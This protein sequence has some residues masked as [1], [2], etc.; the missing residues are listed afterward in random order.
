MRR[1]VLVLAFVSAHALLGCEGS[2]DDQLLL[3]ASSG[4][5]GQGLSGAGASSGSAGNGQAGEG[6]LGGTQGGAGV[7]AL[8]GAG[9]AA[10]VGVGVGGDA[11]AAGAVGGQG[12]A[13]TSAQSDA[14][15]ASGAGGEAGASGVGAGGA[16]G[17]AAG[18]A[19]TSGEPMF[20]PC[21]ASGDCKVL[22][23]GD[24]ITFGSTANVGG[25]R[26]RLFAR[27]HA[28]GKHITF[29]GSQENGP[30]LVEGVPFPRKNEGHPGWTIAQITNI[31]DTSQALR[32]SPQIV[33]LHIGTNDMGSMSMGASDR[34]EQLVDKIVTALPDALL[35][36][37]S[38]IPLPWTD[39]TVQAYNATI[40]GIV[41]AKANEGRHVIHVE[42]HEGFPAHGLDGDNIH[43]DDGVGYPWMGDTW[44]A[45][46]AEYLH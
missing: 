38:I 19:G 44:Y 34:L 17:E 32:D 7:S 29:L 8:G 13:G 26:V 22:P 6:A 24:S 12:G 15:S 16:G 33:L 21:P 42:M 43:P 20:E 46:I 45:A 35:V 2:S 23:L 36:V 25:Y 9:G 1:T 10:G 18:G 3:T 28:D 27:A 40:P 41:Q 11:G 14:G 5:G 4:A 37:S 39:A 30:S 31:A